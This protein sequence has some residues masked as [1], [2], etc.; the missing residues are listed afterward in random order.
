MCNCPRL[1]S[2]DR[3]SLRFIVSSPENG[4]RTDGRHIVLS[5]A[6]ITLSIH[7]DASSFMTYLST[8]DQ[9]EKH[10]QEPYVYADVREGCFC[11]INPDPTPSTQTRYA[12]K[13]A[14]YLQTSICLLLSR[15]HSN[16]LL[17]YQIRQCH[18]S[19]GLESDV[20]GQ[21]ERRG[22]S[23]GN[24]SYGVNIGNIDLNTGVILGLDQLVCPRAFSGDVQVHVLSGFVLHGNV[25]D[26]DWGRTSKEKN[27]SSQHLA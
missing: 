20:S 8:V 23:S 10:V 2:S 14:L 25:C 3:K 6:A 24:S 5:A 19:F 15:Q 9:A 27:V 4:H 1:D 16:I 22:I 11:S 18:I 7:T 26:I 17:L 12:T 13:S 21:A